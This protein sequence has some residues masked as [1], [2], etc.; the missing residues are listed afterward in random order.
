M[1]NN[2]CIHS[3]NDKNFPRSRKPISPIRSKN[4]NC[5]LKDNLPTNAY[6][7]VEVSHNQSLKKGSVASAVYGEENSSYILRK[8]YEAGTNNNPSQLAW[9]EIRG[10]G[11]IDNWEDGSNPHI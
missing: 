9:D 8:T 6:I 11:K 7:P 1:S 4:R 5:I 2:D 10:H 3:S